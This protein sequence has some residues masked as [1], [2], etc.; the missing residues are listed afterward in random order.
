MTRNITPNS[1]LAAYL[2]AVLK[3]P[4]CPTALYNCI[5]ET[6]VNMANDVDPDSA[7]YIER[8]LVAHAAREEKRRQKS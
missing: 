2:S 7:E 8:A 4:A 5:G 3:N 1:E 6:I